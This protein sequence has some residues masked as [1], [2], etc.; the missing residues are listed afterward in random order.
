MLAPMADIQNIKP[1]PKQRPVMAY[2]FILCAVAW[3]INGVFVWN[4]E[5]DI[6]DGECLLGLSSCGPPDHGDSIF[7]FIIP[8]AVAFILAAM[9]LIVRAAQRD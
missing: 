7:T 4:S 3:F 5:N 2:L 6:A 8:A 1:R 9:F